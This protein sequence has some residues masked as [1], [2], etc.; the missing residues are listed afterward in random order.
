MKKK[1][2]SKFVILISL[3]TILILLYIKVFVIGDYIN[4]FKN[5][6]EKNIKQSVEKLESFFLNESSIVYKDNI[7]EEFEFNI[8]HK[9]LDEKKIKYNKENVNRGVEE[10]NLQDNYI[11]NKKEDDI[12]VE[13]DKSI[14]VFK[15]DKNKLLNEIP[16]KDK[17]TVLS[18]VKSLSVKEY[19]ELLNNIKRNDEL[20]AAV[21]IFT[22]LKDNLSHEE[23]EELKGIAEPYLNIQ[24][25]E[26]NIK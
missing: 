19:K 26:D 18:I 3:I 12:F 9:E 17:L 5:E 21:D 13:E 20:G 25:I 7:N 11:E 24:L 8:L 15:T 1:D 16:F 23:Y 6:K 22:I 4:G 2:L 10:E 14:Q